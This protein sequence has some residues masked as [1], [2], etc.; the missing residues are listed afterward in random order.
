MKKATG[1]SDPKVRLRQSPVR[2]ATGLEK[3]ATMGCEECDW[4]VRSGSEIATVCSSHSE[5]DRFDLPL[6]DFKMT[7]CA[8]RSRRNGEED[9]LL[10]VVPQLLS[11]QEP[12]IRPQQV[13]NSSLGCGV[14]DG[15]TI[16]V[17]VPLWYLV[18]VADA[19]PVTLRG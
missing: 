8:G 6:V 15:G 11:H 12:S 4:A 3:N 9:E 10:V 14:P 19:S 7:V 13:L 17:V 2:V 1:W 18:V 16:L 5:H